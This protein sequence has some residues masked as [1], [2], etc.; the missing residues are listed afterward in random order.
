MKFSESQ[1]KKKRRKKK[2]LIS[3]AALDQNIGKY[4][5]LRWEGINST[6]QD[7]EMN[8]YTNEAVIDSYKQ[9]I[10]VTIL[11]KFMRG[12][13]KDS[14]AERIHPFLCFR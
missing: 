5:F 6:D 1:K 13:S 9:Y 7:A 11:D 2:V 3:F 4:N 12:H 14:F 10:E 8:F